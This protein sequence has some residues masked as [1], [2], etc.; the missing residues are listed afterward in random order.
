MCPDTRASPSREHTSMVAAPSWDS[1][2]ALPGLGFWLCQEYRADSKNIAP[3]YFTS[4]RLLFLVPEMEMI[5]VPTLH[6][7]C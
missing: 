5:V 7:C 1:G 3:R 4:L 6:A 2:A